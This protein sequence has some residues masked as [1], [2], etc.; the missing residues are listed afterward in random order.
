MTFF[1]KPLFSR[2]THARLRTLNPLLKIRL[3]RVETIGRQATVTRMIQR[4]LRAEPS[5]LSVHSS[6]MKWSRRRMPMRSSC[7][8]PTPRPGETPIRRVTDDNICRDY[9]SQPS[10]S[11]RDEKPHANGNGP[12]LAL[13]ARPL[14]DWD[15]ESGN[16]LSVKF[17]E[18]LKVGIPTSSFL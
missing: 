8:S 15:A 10:T 1:K 9:F 4:S 12:D 7:L 13:P 18:T 3:G 11:S 14:S 6:K 2:M 5:N 17:S 16:Q